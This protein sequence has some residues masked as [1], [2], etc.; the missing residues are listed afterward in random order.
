MPPTPRRITVR[1]SSPASVHCEQYL[2][3][4]MGLVAMR[5]LAGSAFCF[6]ISAS[7]TSHLMV[8][9]T[10]MLSQQPT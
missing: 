3:L 1:C 8:M 7:S 5:R 10:P 9:V 4:G 2:E 6:G